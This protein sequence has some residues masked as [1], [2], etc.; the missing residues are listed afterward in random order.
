MPLRRAL[1]ELLYVTLLSH[2]GVWLN[3]LSSL[4]YWVQRPFPACTRRSTRL[5]GRPRL[6]RTVDATERILGHGLAKVAFHCFELLTYIVQVSAQRSWLQH[7]HWE[8]SRLREL[9]SRS[10][11]NDVSMARRGP[12]STTDEA[13][14]GRVRLSPASICHCALVTDRFANVL[15]PVLTHNMLT[16]TRIQIIT[17]TAP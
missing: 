6:V 15:C 5:H 7:D 13:I 12:S 10:S 1:T 17:F 2:G 3:A 14:Q 8:Y 16:Q 4:D 11:S 9:A